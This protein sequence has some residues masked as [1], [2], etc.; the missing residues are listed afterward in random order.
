MGPLSRGGGLNDPFTGVT[1]EPSD[2]IDI[3][4]MICNS[5]K[6]YS[7]EVATKII[8]R[9]GGGSPPQEGTVIKGSQHGKVED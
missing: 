7:C 6:N 5:S 8:L 3:Y 1:Y 9:L 2:N 4:T